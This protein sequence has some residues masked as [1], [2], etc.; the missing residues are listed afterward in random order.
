MKR[1]K[2][3]PFDVNQ[4]WLEFGTFGTKEFKQKGRSGEDI[5]RSFNDY[6]REKYGIVLKPKERKP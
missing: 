5:L 6:M 3:Q 1:K 2:R 4:Y